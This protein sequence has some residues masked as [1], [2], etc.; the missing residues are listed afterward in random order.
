MADKRTFV[1]ENFDISYEETKGGWS[2]PYSHHHTHYEIY[3]LL[4]GERTVTIGDSTYQVK[5]GDAALFE[6]NIS[7]RSVGITD[8]SGI[9]IHFSKSYLEHYFLPEIV[10][11][12]LSCFKT[13]VIS[14]PE[15]YC[16]KLLSWSRDESWR[17]ATS[18]LLL[19]RILTDLSAFCR[20]QKKG[21]A[22]SVSTNKASGPSRIL[23]YIDTNYTIIQNV[24]EIAVSCG[25]S[26][27]YIHRA[28]RQSTSFTVKEYINRL[29]LRHAIHE[30]E[31]SDNSFATI[32]KSCGFQSV[33][34]FYRVFKK[35][36]GVTPTQYRKRSHV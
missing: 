2:M 12:Y 21:T 22:S 18:Y 13:P 4:S 29:R 16:Q 3:L 34:Y 15:D 11:S 8:Y 1:Y 24:H 5:S 9:C 28:V 25:V 32:S 30:M 27:A 23:N 7:H 17:S 26:E 35:Y 31:C 6:G 19:A 20:R 14:I 33:T 36:Y 10:A